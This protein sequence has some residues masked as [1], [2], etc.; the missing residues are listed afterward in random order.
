MVSEEQAYTQNIA[1][2]ITLEEAMTLPRAE[3]WRETKREELNNVH[4]NHTF[5]LVPK[6]ANI[7]PIGYKWVFK[8]KLNADGEVTKFKSSFGYKGL[9][10]VPR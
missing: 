1:D 10:A 2:P 7:K 3:M 9:F 6:P 4:S 5:E 8:R